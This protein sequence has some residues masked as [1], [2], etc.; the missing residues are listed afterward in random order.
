VLLALTNEGVSCL[1]RCLLAAVCGTELHTTAAVSLVPPCVSASLCTLLLF[2]LLRDEGDAN[3]P[4]SVKIFQECCVVIKHIQGYY[5]Q[6]Y[7]Y[8][9][10]PLKDNDHI[11]DLTEHK[12]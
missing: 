8:T 7:F 11:S 2:G 10:T 3:H 1:N 9:V 12:I 5:S 6:G 4:V